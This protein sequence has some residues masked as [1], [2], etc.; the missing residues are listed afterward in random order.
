MKS[1]QYV[2]YKIL[3]VMILAAIVGSFVV[4]G[5]FIV[6]LVVLLV[7]VILMFILKRSVN[8]VIADQRIEYIA[9]KASKLTFTIATFLMAISGLILIALRDQYPEYYLIGNILAYLTCGMLFLYTII[10]NY[11]SK[12][13]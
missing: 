6:P 8:E 7:A 3:I 1:K 9:G 13:I 11:Y 5:N 12:K 2:F 4:R 10:F